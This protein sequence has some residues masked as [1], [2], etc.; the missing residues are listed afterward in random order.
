MKK[1]KIVNYDEPKESG[2]IT[3]KKNSKNLYFDF[4]YNGHRIEKS[5]RLPDTPANRRRGRLQLDR[6]IQKIED[7]IFEFAV[8]FPGATEKEKEKFTNLEGQIYN[9]EPQ[10]VIFGDYARYWLENILVNATS[11]GKQEDHS[12]RVN[13][14]ILPYFGNKTFK[15]INRNEIGKFIRQL[16]HENGPNIVTSLT[17]KTIRNILTPLSNIWESACDEYQWEPRNPFRNLDEFMPQDPEP[18][19]DEFDEMIKVFR[20]DEWIE[21]IKNMDPH[22]QPTA[23]YMIMTGT[24]ASEVAGLRTIDIKN[25]HL[26]VRNSISKGREKNSLKNKYRYRRLPLT[27]AIRTRINA[28]KLLSAGSYPFRT[29]TGIEFKEGTFRKNYWIPALKKAGVDYKTPYSTR[30]TF[31]AWALTIGMNIDRVVSLMGHGSRKMVY[32]VYGQYRDGLEQ[33]KKKILAY[34]GKDFLA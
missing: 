33:D 17:K 27:N 19:L 24:I 34:F 8:A 10:N 9:S 23:E 30:H 1:G 12:G 28:A 3:K 22:Y 4:Y 16:N 20:F 7:G 18:A 11:E 32:E 21:V 2:S 14:K 31:A 6:F 5:T 26:L 13:G 25:E 15:E 29:K